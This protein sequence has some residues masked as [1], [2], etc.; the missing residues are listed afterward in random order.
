M[1]TPTPVS[2]V[3]RQNVVSLA[4]AFAKARNIKLA[5]V[6]RKIRGDI[7]FL[8]D[9]RSGKISVTSKKYDEIIK[10]FCDNWPTGTPMPQIKEF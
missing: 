10:Y 4:T 8:N 3:L 7:H 5:T 1:M 6:S 9:Y 2:P